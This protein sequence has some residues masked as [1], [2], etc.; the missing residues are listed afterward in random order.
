MAVRS[1]KKISANIVLIL[2]AILACL[3]LITRLTNLTILPIFFD[4]ANYIFW[5]KRI[6]TGQAGIFLPLAYGKPVPFIWLISS[7]LTILPSNAYLIAGRLPSVAFGLLTLLGIYKSG[8]LIFNSKKVGLIAGL[9]YCFLPFTLF[10]DRMTLYDSMLTMFM[11][12]A[13]YFTFKSA[14][15][16]QKKDAL[17]WGV[18]LGLALLTKATA[19]SYLWLTVIVFVLNIQKRFQFRLIAIALLASQI[20]ANLQI[21][22]GGY[23]EYIRKSIDYTPGGSSLSK[24][25]TVFI[26][27]LGLSW[28]WLTTYYTLPFFL[29]CLAALAYLL[30]NKWKLG[31]SFLLLALTPIFAFSLLGRIYFARYLLFTT[32]IFLLAGSYL[33]SKLP[34][35]PALLVGVIFIFTML[36][37]DYALL[38]KPEVTPFPQEDK[39]Q[40]VTGYPSGYGLEKIYSYIRAESASEPVCLI[41]QGSFSHYP[42]AFHLEF[43]DNGNIYIEERWPLT[44]EDTQTKQCFTERGLAL[45]PEIIKPQPTDIPSKSYYILR[46]DELAGLTNNF[47]YLKLNKLVVSPKPVGKDSLYIAQ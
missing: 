35:Y 12:W 37:F 33:L 34:R 4:E 47:E 32:P 23:L 29:F 15:T 26:P 16:L 17:L 22:S 20:V 36:P 3:I 39:W 11:T 5:A 41:I 43:W 28:E 27:N 19:L 46:D 1:T 9:F 25:D 10:H 7:L 31:V 2:L 45:Q 13:V 40:Y 14:R 24:L 6:A 30:T 21:V 18:M 38:F 42:N 44:P 8:S